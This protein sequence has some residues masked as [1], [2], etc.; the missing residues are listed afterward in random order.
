VDRDRGA[1]AQEELRDLPERATAAFGAGTQD[2]LE[3]PVIDRRTGVVIGVHACGAFAVRNGAIA[4][5]ALFAGPAP[6][7]GI[8]RQRFV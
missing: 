7:D 6:R 2:A 5:A 1:L 4:T 3:A 8:G